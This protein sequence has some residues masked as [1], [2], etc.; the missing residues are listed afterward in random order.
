MQHR[1][2]SF[3]LLAAAAACAAC[4]GPKPPPPPPSLSADIAALEQE[5]AGAKAK[6]ARLKDFDDLENLAAIYGYYV[7]KSRHDDVAD[8]FAK[9][10]NLEIYGRG[11]F[12]G[13][14]RVR[15]YQH[16]FTPGSIGPREGSLFN[17]MHL[18]PVIHVAPDGETATVRSRALIMFGILNTNA[19]WGDA[20]YENQFVKQDGVWKIEYLH[21]YQTFYTNYE[22]GWAKKSSAL[23]GEYPRL[24]P[25]RHQTV[26]YEVYPGA[27]VP[28]F[29][30]PNP[31]SGRKDHYADPSLRE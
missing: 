11:V 20:I 8:L 7:D 25:D 2:A 30:Y 31:V 27:F 5:V 19:Q 22:D 23:F 12:L 3:P 24:P 1:T 16:N 21:P 17:H 9:D 28:P 29:D 4:S 18:Q 15:E 14:D 26:K 13:Q 10:G 6:L